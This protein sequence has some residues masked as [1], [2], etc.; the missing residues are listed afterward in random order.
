MIRIRA[1]EPERGIHGH[2]LTEA[3]QRL[4]HRA[5]EPGIVARVF[6]PAIEHTIGM[7]R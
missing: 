5:I 4:D 7:A 6:E 3:K 1:H 2:L